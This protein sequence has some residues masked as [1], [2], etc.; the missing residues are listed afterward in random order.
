MEPDARTASPGISIPDT[1]LTVD[2]QPAGELFEPHGVGAAA[3][4][5]PS[6]AASATTLPTTTARDDMGKMKEQDDKDAQENLLPHSETAEE[7]EAR[8]KAERGKRKIVSSHAVLLLFTMALFVGIR[9]WNAIPC[10]PLVRGPGLLASLMF[11]LR[12]FGG[13]SAD[14]WLTIG[15]ATRSDQHCESTDRGHGEG[16]C[17]REGELKVCTSR[18]SETRKAISIRI[19][20]SLMHAPAKAYPLL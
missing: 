8:L 17:G 3:K 16:D 11:E 13:V 4:E 9:I 1:S 15:I 2:L 14:A 18:S 5:V 10:I 20:A 19:L 6:D 7:K 12:S